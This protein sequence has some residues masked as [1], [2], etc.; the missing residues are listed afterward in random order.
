MK[1]TVTFRREIKNVEKQLHLKNGLF[2]IY[3]VYEFMHNLC[4]STMQ[5]ERCDT[6]IT[7]NLPKNSCGYFTSKFKT[8][9]T[10]QICGDTQQIW[11][12]IL[13]RSLTGKIVIKKTD[14]LTFL[15]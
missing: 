6:E 13:N 3:A 10:E 11:I 9:K 7:V 4:V 12:R 15:F 1:S 2:L 14:G 8:D 5:L